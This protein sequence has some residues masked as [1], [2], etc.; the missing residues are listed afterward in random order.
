LTWPDVTKLCEEA[1]LGDGLSLECLR[2]VYLVRD[3]LEPRR[4]GA[5]NWVGVDGPDLVHI[6][7]VEDAVCLEWRIGDTL[8]SRMTVTRSWHENF[9]LDHDGK[10]HQAKR[11]AFKPFC[12]AR[13]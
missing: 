12:R 3:E 11:E 9:W 2:Q 10:R 5:G 13:P 7:P 8:T 1:F 6:D 4:D